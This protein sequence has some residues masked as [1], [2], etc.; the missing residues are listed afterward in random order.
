MA[1]PL[2]KVQE[3]CSLLAARLT[4]IG[5]IF[6][7][8]S[9][10]FFYLSFFTRLLLSAIF[11]SNLPYYLSRLQIPRTALNALLKATIQ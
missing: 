2:T 11:C 10:L 7:S 4:R 3:A 6:L 8:F 9:A 1:T 5:I